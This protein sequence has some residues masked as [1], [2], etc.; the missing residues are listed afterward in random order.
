MMHS[1]SLIYH[2]IPSILCPVHAG[3]EFLSS[4][5][6]F[7]LLSEQQIGHLFALAERHDLQSGSVL[8][9]QGGECVVVCCSVFAVRG[10]ASA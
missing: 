3:L 1:N 6:A 5:D 2:T 9:P 4:I 10:S 8:L 7:K